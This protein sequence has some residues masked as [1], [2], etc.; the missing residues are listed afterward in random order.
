MRARPPSMAATNRSPNTDSDP[1][2]GFTTVL[3]AIESYLAKL[4]RERECAEEASRS[5]MVDCQNQI[6]SN[7]QIIQ[8]RRR[9]IQ[10][11][12][13]ENEAHRQEY[14]RLQGA[15]GVICEKHQEKVAQL[16][17]YLQSNVR[18]DCAV[19][20]SA[21]AAWLTFV[22]TAAFGQ[23]KQSPFPAATEGVTELPRR[24]IVVDNSGE[25]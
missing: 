3:R 5:S 23:W 11:L 14:L 15:R 25:P 8:Q 19:L 6:T 21:W 16:K 2:E 9:E 10:Q 4:T 12:E 22:V 20:W 18:L 7:E 17:R 24:F 13:Q 1:D